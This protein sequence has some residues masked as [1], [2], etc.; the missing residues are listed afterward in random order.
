MPATE[1]PT[2]ELLGGSIRITLPGTTFA[3]GEYQI[4]RRDITATFNQISTT[5]SQSFIDTT[6]PPGTTEACY[7]VR[8]VDEC[9]NVSSASSEVCVIIEA[10][11]GIPTAFS[12]NGDNIN[13]FFSVSD[14]IYN[15]FQMLIYNQWGTLVFQTNNPSPG[16]NGTF[17]GSE[18]PS[19]S[20]SYRVIFQNADNT[21][22]NRSGT[23]VL[24]R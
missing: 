4:L 8:Y 20:Y 1:A 22:V 2:A 13:D 16:W 3:L 7:Q 10:K 19:G 6:I 17:E 21:S 12:P 18:A 11:L 9:G 23:F 14:G 24:I 15:N 5:I